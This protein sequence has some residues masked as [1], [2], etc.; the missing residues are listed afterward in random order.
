MIPGRDWCQQCAC[1]PAELTHVFVS[2]MPTVRLKPLELSSEEKK[3]VPLK[4]VPE[5]VGGKRPGNRVNIILLFPHVFVSL[6]HCDSILS[7]FL[8]ISVI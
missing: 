4:H 3:L 7:L 2:E 1:H 8:K 5:L 6:L